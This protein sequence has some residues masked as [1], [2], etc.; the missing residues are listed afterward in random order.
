M[1]S[2][3]K[4]LILK[5]IWLKL[6]SL[7][8]ATLI[9]FTVNIAIQNQVSPVAA[10][11]LIKPDRRTFSN[12]PVVVMSSAQDARSATVNPKEV[13]VTVEGDAKV[14][15]SLY[16]RDIR[17][18]VDLTGIEAAHDMR[19]RVE[20]STPSG[21]THVTVDPPEVQVIFPPKS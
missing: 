20:V 16:N 2:S 19:K 3:L 9:W 4:D 15:K 13:D 14:L 6:F 21:V 10:L 5:D 18:L 11:P 1:T 12:L 8:L 7:A 17:V